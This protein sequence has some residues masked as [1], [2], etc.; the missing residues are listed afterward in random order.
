MGNSS[1]TTTQEPIMKDIVSADIESYQPV[2][3]KIYHFYWNTFIEQ[4][5]LIGC[6]YIL[7]VVQ[8]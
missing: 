3:Y 2:E 8:K 6:A 4:R 5:F 1:I 7:L